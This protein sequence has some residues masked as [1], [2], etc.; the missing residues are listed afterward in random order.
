M[1]ITEKILS[2]KAGHEVVP[3][4]II[5]IDVLDADIPRDLAPS[6]WP[7]STPFIPER[8]ISPI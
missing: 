5:E 1:N 6:S 7:L 2:K 4:E 3:G 8:T